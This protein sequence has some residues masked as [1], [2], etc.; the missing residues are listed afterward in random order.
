LATTFDTPPSVGVSY[1]TVV[2]QLYIAYFGRPADP[3]GFVNFENALFAVNAPTDIAGLTAAYSTSTAVKDYVDAFGLSAES[4]RLYTGTTRD[5]V[6]SIFN[7][8]LNRD[9][10]PAPGAGLD[11]WSTRIDD[12]TVTL[13]NAALAIMNG[14][15]EN[16]SAQ[17]LLDAAAV[18]NKIKVALDFTAS[19]DTASEINAYKG[20]T[21]AGT[22]RTML[23]TVNDATDTT[24]FHATVTSTLTSLEASATPAAMHAQSAPQYTEQPVMLM[25]IHG[26][27]MNWV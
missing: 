11:Y 12:G 4:A 8:V 20:Q 26:P 6:T 16:T 2:Q 1:D 15:L 22:A 9:P 19:C 27:D 5:F 10:N 14:A 21:A 13:G 17:G 23:R 3:A 24:V 25:G 7:N 18:N